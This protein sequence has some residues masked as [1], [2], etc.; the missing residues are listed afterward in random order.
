MSRQVRVVGKVEK[1]TKEE[2]EAYFKSRP[3]GSR[4]GAWA[5]PQSRV[6]GEGEVAKKVEEI[7][8]RFGIKSNDEA[9]DVEVPLPDH[10]GGWRIVP[11]YVS[12]VP[13]SSCCQR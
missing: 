13:C 9:V 6:V 8:Q 4:I 1:I 10:W 7:G 12:Y 11:T 5:S 3:L 2:S